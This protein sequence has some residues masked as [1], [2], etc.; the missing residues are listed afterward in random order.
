MVAR[1]RGGDI[2]IRTVAQAVSERFAATDQELHAFISF[3][4][5]DVLRQADVMEREGRLGEL[6]GVPMAIKDNVDVRGQP[7]TAGTSFL[8]DNITHP[9][10]HAVALLPAHGPLI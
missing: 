5:V 9:D 3:D 4:T 2:A 7:T 6:G 8:H 1:V 10:A